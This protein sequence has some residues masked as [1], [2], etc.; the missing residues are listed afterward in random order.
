[1]S[2]M[3]FMAIMTMMKYSNGVETTS[4]Q[5]RNLAEFLFLGM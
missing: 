1:M 4:F 3:V 2:T 5:T